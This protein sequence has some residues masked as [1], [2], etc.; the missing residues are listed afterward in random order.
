MTQMQ[1]NVGALQSKMD[2]HFHLVYVLVFPEDVLAGD[3]C[4]DPLDIFVRSPNTNLSGKLNLEHLNLLG[5]NGMQLTHY[6]ILFWS[7]RNLGLLGR[8]H[9][10][11]EF[12]IVTCDFWF[13]LK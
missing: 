13:I 8:R 1:D 10:G 4:W 3:H 11:K 12:V 5:H 7:P 2:E 9:L 6:Q